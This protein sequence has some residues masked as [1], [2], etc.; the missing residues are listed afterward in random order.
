[1]PG[2]RPGRQELRAHRVHD[3]LQE[4]LNRYF[5]QRLLNVAQPDDVDRDVDVTGLFGD[6]I[7]IRVDGLFVQGVHDGCLRY[8]AARADVA[9][10]LVEL[11]L[12]V[13]GEEDRGSLAGKGA[14]D[15]AADRATCA[16]HDSDFV[17]QQHIYSS[18]V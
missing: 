14:G 6:A 15:G 2:R 12:G 17:L 18:L 7:H 4:I 11:G 3:R 5:S 13:T 9:G 10:N 1:M 16:I 8:A